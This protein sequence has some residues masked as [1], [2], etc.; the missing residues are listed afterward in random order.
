MFRFKYP[1]LMPHNPEF[2]LIIPKETGDQFYMRQEIVID[3]NATI[4][5]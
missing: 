4:Y 3:V 2:D 5:T 1:F